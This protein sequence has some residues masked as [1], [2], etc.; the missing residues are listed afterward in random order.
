MKAAIFK[1]TAWVIFLFCA[2]KKQPGHLPTPAPP[3]GENTRIAIKLNSNY[4]SEEKVDSAILVWETA[5]QVQRKKMQR[6]NDTLFT[7][8]NNLNRG[9]GRL[10]IQI[11]SKA[12]VRGQ[13]LQFEKRMDTI[14]KESESINLPAPTGYDDPVWL[15]RVILID[16]FTHF[17]AI[18][19]L[20][21]AD[22]YFLLKNVPSG[23]KIELERNYTVIPG[24]AESVGG[25]L[26]KCNSVCTDENGII[27]NRD[28][29]KLLQ[30]KIGNRQWKMVEVGVGLFGPNNSSGGVLYFNHW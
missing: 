3:S 29:F 10:T 27:E 11:Y 7:M 13:N 14:L 26:W 15:P 18:I 5:G 20:R 16:N 19:A 9:E 23:F 21:P 24:G 17:T 6:S 4:L 1:T 22:P 8:L 2:C 28:F 30:S 12:A 25:G